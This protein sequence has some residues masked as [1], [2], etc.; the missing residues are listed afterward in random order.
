MY[1]SGTV[2]ASPVLLLADPPESPPPPSPAPAQ[3]AVPSVPAAKKGL[4]VTQL[5]FGRGSAADRQAALNGRASPSPSPTPSSPPP[6]A[7]LASARGQLAPA[8][9]R[10]ARSPS[11]GPRG[12]YAPTVWAR[13]RLTSSS[14]GA[15]T[16]GNSPRPGRL[17]V[18]ASFEQR[19]AGLAAPVATPFAALKGV[20]EAALAEGLLVAESSP[21]VTAPASAATP[22][23]SGGV[24]TVPEAAG[25]GPV[26]SILSSL[27]GEQAGQRLTRES[28]PASRSPARRTGPSASYAAHSVSRKPS[29]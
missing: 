4:S 25:R 22:A 21:R 6:S 16:A 1:R 7:V 23:A 10:A 5:T 12:G 17:A 9:G 15:A 28:L 3:A 26:P 14:G 29:N 8:P 27:S 18:D 20:A 11:P 24:A 13:R 2:S 19:G